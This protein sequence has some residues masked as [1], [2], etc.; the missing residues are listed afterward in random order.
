MLNETGLSGLLAGCRLGKPLSCRETVDSTNLEVCRAAGQGA[1]EGL[2][3]QAEEQTAGRG[4]RGRSWLS[5]PGE[6]LYFSLLLRPDID[7]EKTHML[8]P[9]MALA[10]A[11][12]ARSLGIDALIKWPND[13]VA[14]GHKLCGILTELHLEA[15]G[16]YVVIGTGIN[17]N[18]RSFPEGLHEATSLCLE[19]GSGIDREELLARVLRCFEECYGRFLET[20]DLS[21]LRAGYEALLVNRGRTVEVLDPKGAWKGE[22]LGI[23]DTGELLVRRSDGTKEAVFA[24]EVSVRGIYGYV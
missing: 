21:G 1:P 12:S 22:A 6:N 19:K 18:Q 14:R 11:K 16:F 3:V 13:V 20:Q 5:P 9:L 8:T 4:R 24:G 2:L 23:L 15:E 10:V 17:V 7:P